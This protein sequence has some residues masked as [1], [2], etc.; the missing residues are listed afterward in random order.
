MSMDR[1]VQAKLPLLETSLKKWESL[2][3]TLTAL[4]WGTKST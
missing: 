2:T 3:V 1:P 4:F